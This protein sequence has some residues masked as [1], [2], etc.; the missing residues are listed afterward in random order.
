MTLSSFV[1]WEDV[2]CTADGHLADG[3]AAY[4]GLVLRGR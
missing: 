2:G 1:H 3:V 4:A